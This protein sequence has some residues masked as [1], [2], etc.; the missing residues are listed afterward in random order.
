MEASPAGV[1]RAAW[2]DLGVG[3]DI[4]DVR[5][6]SANV[7]TNRVY[8]V[9]LEGGDTVVC[10]VSS[11][12]SY[13][14]F[15]EDHDR[16]HRCAKMLVGNPETQRWAPFLANVLERDGRPLTWYDGSIWAVFYQDVP[17]AES[18]PRILS[19]SQVENL[20]REM[21]EFHAACTPMAKQLPP[22]SNSVKG[23]LIH[24][25]DLLES[26]FA[27]KN[28]NLAPEHIGVLHRDTHQLLL[29]FEAVHYDEWLRIPVLIDWNLG[30]FSVLF[31]NTDQ[32]QG[33]RLFSRWDYDW[34]RLE[35]RVFDFYFLSRVSSSTGDRTT[36]TYSPH[37]LLEPRFLA[38]LRAYHGVY[39]LTADEVRFIPLAYRF[40]LLNYVIREGA[41]FFRD[42]LC[43]QFREEVARRYL[44][45]VAQLD[46]SPLLEA[47][48]LEG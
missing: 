38:L 3:R 27:A 37:T 35:S 20:G 6:I 30:N 13:F 17:R 45:Q 18:L 4:L 11:Y 46:F 8:R 15:A 9:T 28:F 31:S 36:F 10:K 5:E 42:D 14:L 33:F 2:A 43:R 47:L 24:L 21:A 41:R 25:L 26:P 48:E 34:F 7:S 22:T 44:R 32:G 40:F 19:V 23:D 12:G 1:V 39:P 16:L 29:Q